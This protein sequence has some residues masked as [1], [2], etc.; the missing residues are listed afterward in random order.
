MRKLSVRAQ[1]KNELKGIQFLSQLLDEM[2]FDHT[3]DSYK[4]AALNTFTRVVELKAVATEVLNGSAPS[5]TLDSFVEELNF[6]LETEEVL[7][8]PE[9]R[10]FRK[11]LQDAKSN[12]D[13]IHKFVETVSAIESLLAEY[14]ERICEKLKSLILD[15][16]REKLNIVR[17]ASDFIVQ[18]EANG[19]SRRYVYSS[20]KQK[21]TRG[22]LERKNVSAQRLLDDFFGCFCNVAKEWIVY[23]AFDP[24]LALSELS[25]RFGIIYGIDFEGIEITTEEASSFI[26][27][28][29]I[30]GKVFLGCKVSG[31]DPLVALEMGQRL[32]GV[33][34]AAVGF[35]DH[36]CEIRFDKKGIVVDVL[37]KSAYEMQ[38]RP[39]AMKVNTR[40]SIALKDGLSLIEM[41]IDHGQEEKEIQALFKLL[42]LVSLH[43]V[44]LVENNPPNQLV[45]LWSALEG[46]MPRPGR[47]AVRISHFSDQLSR[48]LTLSYAEK[49]FRVV[50]AELTG[51]GKR[52]RNYMELVGVD[53][54]NVLE[55]ASFVC[56]SEFE[57]ERVKLLGIIECDNPL[58][59]FRLWS[60][61]RRFSSNKK[62]LN[63]L[64]SHQRKLKWQIFRI[65]YSRN[66]IVHAANVSDNVASLVE[67]LHAYIDQLTW[68]ILRVLSSRRAGTVEQ[69]MA[70]LLAHETLILE[71]LSNSKDI[72][73]DK[74]NIYEFVFGLNNPVSPLKLIE[75]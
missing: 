75:N 45:D 16:A 72:V 20:V 22:L 31:K 41:V 71:D 13:N 48:V 58:L 2:L 19:Y 30:S 29:A 49:L 46:F 54:D 57:A 10:L 35:C 65:Y 36:E 67:H 64:Q 62:I 32:V 26:G 21:L 40:G 39:N 69:A 43:G 23:F 56:S 9:I 24:N 1:N 51:A 59:C 47:D 68:S 7:S 14:F 63:T 55:V 28:A 44:G 74:N 17:V 15:G 73:C 8:N 4:A 42:N 52:A 70:I 11:M 33:C 18:C 25:D 27:T 12:I 61:N 3:D 53:L 66:S 60:L 38:G 37:E 34:V 5:K 50:G 6:S